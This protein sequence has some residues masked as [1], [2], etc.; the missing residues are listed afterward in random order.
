MVE[1]ALPRKKGVIVL[2]LFVLAVVLAISLACTSLAWDDRSEPQLTIRTAVPTLAPTPAPE[3]VQ[4]VQQQNTPTAVVVAPQAPEAVPDTGDG[5]SAQVFESMAQSMAFG[6]GGEAQ[7]Y[8]S[9]TARVS[10]VIQTDG[11]AQLTATGPQFFDHVNCTPTKS[12]ETWIVEGAVDETG[13]QVDFFSC[14]FGG[15]QASGAVRLADGAL[16]GEFSCLTADG[17]TAVTLIL[18]P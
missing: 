18:N 15:F 13:A 7:Y 6:S 4:P 14:N 17:Q 2:R 10:L 9:A 16:A 5:G 3:D 11:K 1:K 12:Q 8:C